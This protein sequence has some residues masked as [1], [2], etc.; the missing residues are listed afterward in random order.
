MKYTDLALN[1]RVLRTFYLSILLSSTL[2]CSK[3]DTPSPTN[4]APG[5]TTTYRSVSGWPAK[6]SGVMLQGF[7]W[8][9]FGETTWKQLEAQANELAPYFSLVWIPQSGK[10]QHNPSMGYDV[11]YWYNHNSSFGTESEL[12]SL[13][14]TFKSNGIGTI[15]DVVINHRGNVSSWTDFPREEYKGII[16]QMTK[17][18]ITRDDEAAANGYSVGKNKDTGDNWSGMRDLDHRSEHIQQ[19]VITYLQFL[20]ND[21]GYAG[22]RYDLVK[23]YAP[24]YTR[25][26]NQASQI[27][28][29]VGEYWDGNYDSVKAWLDGTADEERKIQSAAFDFPAKYAINNACNNGQWANLVW[30]RNNVLPQPA[31]LIH[32]N[33][34]QRYAI[35]FVDNHDTFRPLKPLEDQENRD[36]VKQNIMAANAF[37]LTMPGTPCVFYPHWVKYKSELKTLIQARQTAGVHSE[38]EVTVVKADNSGYVAEVKGT[39]KTLLVKLGPISY[40]APNSY[41]AVASGE[42]YNLWIK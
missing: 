42:N 20:K 33:G 2:A 17:D 3:A 15:A 9:S 21:L 18:D 36:A 4:S 31:G 28:F 5:T 7:Y 1:Q 40:T 32:M 39:K 6:Y 19:E 38:S 12:R 14:S 23:G 11:V 29:S 13:I 37:I 16:H 30:M 25:L 35:T 8:D 22:F 10:A 41:T 26:Y 27:A 34:L 24:R